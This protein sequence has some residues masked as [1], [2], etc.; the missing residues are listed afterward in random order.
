ME[1][2]ELRDQFFAE[3]HRDPYAHMLFKS[4]VRAWA[5]GYEQALRDHGLTEARLSKSFSERENDA[6]EFLTE[7]NKKASAQALIAMAQ[8]GPLLSPLPALVAL[9]P[10]TPRSEASD[11]A[12]PADPDRKIH[13]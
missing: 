10:A 7:A 6:A 3:V 9:R 8:I 1:R 4:Y 13:E 5:D 11:S 12:S 2:T